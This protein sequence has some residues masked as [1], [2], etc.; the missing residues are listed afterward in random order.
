M[1]IFEQI[2]WSDGGPMDKGTVIKYLLGDSEEQLKKRFNIDHSFIS[3]R[4]ISNE[5][6]MKRKVEAE[7][8]LKI[9]TI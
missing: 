5:E 2:E 9:F 7:N 1:T 6:Y 4:E 3:F 8:H